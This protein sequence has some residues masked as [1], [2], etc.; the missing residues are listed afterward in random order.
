MD[1]KPSLEPLAYVHKAKYANYKPNTDLD[2]GTR[3][4]GML[5]KAGFEVEAAPHFDWRIDTFPVIIKMFPEGCPPTVIISQNA[6]YDPYYHMQIGAAL[7][8]LRKE[9]YLFIGSGGGVHNLYRADWKYNIQYRDVFAMLSPPDR[10]HLEFR[11]ALE[12]VICR[13]GGG[14]EL[15]R[16]LIR[17]IKHPNYRDAHGTDDHYM[18]AC[19]VAGLA[20]DEEDRGSQGVLGAEC[21]ELASGHIR[22][23]L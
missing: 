6:Y 21:W 1:P 7:R 4:I 11:Q 3:C 5:R 9:G 19:F 18:P 23:K 15:K 13:N 17:L 8:P 14:P 2:T 20:G 22:C 10:T 12:D 16:G